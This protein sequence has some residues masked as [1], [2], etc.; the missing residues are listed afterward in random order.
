[1]LITALERAWEEGLEAGRAASHSSMPGTTG[2]KKHKLEGK[3][4]SRE[5]SLAGMKP[6]AGP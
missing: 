2:K 5:N 1:M 3:R 4:E 6:Q